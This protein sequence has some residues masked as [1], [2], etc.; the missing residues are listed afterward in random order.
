M[1]T[2]PMDVKVGDTVLCLKDG[3][4]RSRSMQETLDLRESDCSH[5]SNNK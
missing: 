2:H 1:K 4:T 3:G 5:L